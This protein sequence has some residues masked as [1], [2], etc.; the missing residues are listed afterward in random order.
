[1]LRTPTE[2]IWKGVSSLPEYKAIF[3]NWTTFT[4]AKQAK[5]LD[6]EGIDLLSKMLVYDPSK[7]ISAKG[8]ATHPYF[9]DLDLK[10]KPIIIEK[11]K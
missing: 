9:K 5:N 8:V 7:R 2:E 3:P 10:V 1:M 11:D 4:L 6:E